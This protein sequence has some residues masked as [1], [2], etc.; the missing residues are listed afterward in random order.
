MEVRG[1][2]ILCQTYSFVVLHPV[3]FITQQYSYNI[4]LSICL[5]L[6]EP[7][8]VNTNRRAAAVYYLKWSVHYDLDSLI[9]VWNSFKKCW[10]GLKFKPHLSI[11]GHDV[12]ATF[13]RVSCS[14][15]SADVLPRS[16]SWRWVLG[17]CVKFSSVRTSTST[18]AQSASAQVTVNETSSLTTITCLM[19]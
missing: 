12:F 18:N 4:D 10:F 16:S 9:T 3:Y 14:P 13:F 17:F 8:Q 6:C 2:V 5:C 7:N 1:S 11:I 19:D 15:D